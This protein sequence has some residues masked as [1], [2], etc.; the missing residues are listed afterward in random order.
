MKIKKTL[1]APLHNRVGIVPRGRDPCCAA[2]GLH[3]LRGT[4]IARRKR[5]PVELVARRNAVRGADSAHCGAA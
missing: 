2:K 1:P 4:G 5:Q 3:G